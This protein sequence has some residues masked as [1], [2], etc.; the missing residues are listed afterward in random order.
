MAL[1]DREHGVGRRTRVWRAGLLAAVLLASGACGPLE[2]LIERPN[3]V[4]I[5]LDTTRPDFLGTYSGRDSS[6]NLDRLARES[7]VYTRAQSTANWTL[8]AHASLFTGKFTTSHGARY[9]ADGPLILTSA[10]EGHEGYKRYRARGLAPEERTLAQILQEHGYATAAFVG[11]PWLKRVMGVDTGFDLYDDDG[12]LGIGGR[13]AP[14]LTDRAIDWIRTQRDEPMFV[15]LNYF[16]PHSPYA[17]PAVYLRAPRGMN[18]RLDAERPEMRRA[19]YEGEIRYMDFDLGRLLGELRALGLYDRTWIIV[20]G[21]HGEL[22]GEHGLQGHGTTLHKELTHIPLV[23][24]HPKGEGSVGEV[25][26]P[27]QLVDIL[28]TILDRLDLPLPPG[29]QGSPLDA[30]DHPV[31][32]ESYPLPFFENARGDVRALIEGDYKLIWSSSGPDE[33]YR[34]STDPGEAH[35]LAVD[36]PER[37]EAMR[38]RLS[39]Y[40]ESLPRPLEAGTPTEVDAET[41][42]ALRR[43]GYVE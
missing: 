17:P 37:A 23:I 33:L 16:D 25:D 14:E 13:A 21:D 12:I 29:I 10:I 43:L 42:E 1:K 8:P 39:A 27:A 28:P 41:R 7:T 15:F 18:P 24:K 3:I 34:L 4:L 9:D 22:L 40:L 5:T 26:A 30:L 32:A 38:Q 31:V 35:N 6:P 2:P 19:L 11:G 36:E 20:T